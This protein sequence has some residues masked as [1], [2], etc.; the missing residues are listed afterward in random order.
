[1]PLLPADLLRN[2]IFLRAARR[3]EL[4][5]PLYEKYWKE[6]D[7]DFW[8]KQISQGRLY[9]PRSDMFIG[10][11]LAS[12][13]AIDVPLSHLYVEYKHWI[14]K[15]NPFQSVEE[16]LTELQARRL[17]YKSILEGSPD[18]D[19][20]PLTKFLNAFDIGTVYPVLLFFD[21]SGILIGERAS[22]GHAIESYLLRRAVCGLP[23]NN[24]N[25][26]FLGLI[27]ALQRGQP[28]SANLIDYLLDLKGETVE[29][30]SDEALVQEWLVG[31]AYSRLNNPKL[32]YLLTRLSATYAGPKIEDITVNVSLTIEH[33]MPQGWLTQ[34]PLPG[35]ARGVDAL[36]LMM[37]PPE[38]IHAAATTKR[39]RAVQTLGNLTVL[40]KP[41]NSAVSNS[42]WD[43]KKPQLLANSLL[44][45]NQMLHSYENWDETVI[46]TRGRDLLARAQKLWSKPATKTH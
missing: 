36:E 4:P 37:L 14:E 29:W 39:N 45:I 1:V 19:F 40:T 42:R 26:V 11:F 43:V 24:Y 18:G 3:K 15:C 6:F 16:E 44:P 31:H 21:A 33:I 12:K 20:Y 17:S 5:I 8:R 28:T 38:D 23:T 25:R 30:P 7:T 34:W 32:V 13:Q 41:L 2:Y 27:R 22:V 10:H 46:E 9:R 35:G